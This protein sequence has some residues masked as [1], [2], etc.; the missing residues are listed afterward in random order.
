MS[1]LLVAAVCVASFGLPSTAKAEEMNIAKR[2]AL[3][4]QANPFAGFAPTVEYWTSDNF[5]LSASVSGYWYWTTIGVRGTY[6][7]DNRIEIF[8][9]PARPYAGAGVGFTSWYGGASTPGLEVFGG[10]L[11]P[12]SQNVSVRAELNAASYGLLH[13]DADHP[14]FPLGIGVGIFYHFGG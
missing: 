7:F 13:H 6:L 8:S 11:Q 1:V 14:W 10:L 4:L 3:G 9:M 5:G 2:W 12:F